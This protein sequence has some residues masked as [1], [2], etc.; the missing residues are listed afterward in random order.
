MIVASTIVPVPRSVRRVPHPVEQRLAQIVLLEQLVK[1][2]HRRLVGHRLAAKI[3]PD[4]TPHRLRTV[5]RLFDRWVQQ[6]ERVLQETDA[7]H[8][9]DPDRRAAVAGL[10]VEWLD[11][12]AQHRLRHHALHPGQKLRPPRRIRVALKPHHRRC[13]LFHP[14]TPPTNRS[15]M[16]LISPP[17]TNRFGGGSVVADLGKLSRCRPKRLLTI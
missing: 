9:L 15:P 13:R 11:Q 12:P 2:G 16:R 8:P 4:K 17:L 1:A 14:P 3:D 5:K 6:I 10:W 7:E